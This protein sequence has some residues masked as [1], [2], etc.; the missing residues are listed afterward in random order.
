MHRRGVGA[1]AIAK[2]KLA[3]ASDYITSIFFVLSVKLN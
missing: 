2:K 3:E 1:G